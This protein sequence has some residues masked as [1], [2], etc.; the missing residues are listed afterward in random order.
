VFVVSSQGRFFCLNGAD[1]T[2]LWAVRGLPQT[3]SLMNNASPAVDGD[4]VVVPYS[5]GD[6][7]A[8]R[9][10]DGTA[11]WTENLTRTRSSSQ[12]DSLTDAARPAID[13]GV[14]YAVGH[15]G[16]MVATVLKSG[17]RQW[18]LNVA[19]T[20]TPWVAGETVF[21]VTTSG[22]L[23]ALARRDGKVQWTAQL[24]AARV[25]TGP[26]LA[27]GS[28]WLASDKGKIVSVDAM[29]GKLGAQIDI[30]APVFIAPVVAQGRMFILTDKAKLVALN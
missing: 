12:L 7:V 8:L 5:S 10:K 15:S 16:R 24:P 21:V 1:G 25:W 27:G 4:I 22:Q 17:D 3:A 6:L 11:V 20:Q 18:S 2:E 23:M 29:T 9:V 19:G 28:L 30:D 14:V 26:T 13:N